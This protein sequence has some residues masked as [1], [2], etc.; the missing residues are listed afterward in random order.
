MPLKI[1][2]VC[3]YHS[4]MDVWFYAAALFAEIIGTMAG[5]GS[6]TILLPIALLFFDFKTA[7]VLV[8]FMH[9]F[10]NL[11]RSAFF[12]KGIHWRVLL[13]FG[14][15][16]V[17]ATS[18][19][20]LLVT[21][22]NQ[23]AL[24]GLLGVFLIIYGTVALTKFRLTLASSKR[25]M[26]IGGSVSGFFAGLIGTGGALRGAFL[27]A[28]TLPK[29]QYIGTAAA[30]AFLV[31]ITRI[32]VYLSS[33]LL[34]AS[35]YWTLPVLFMLAIIGSFIGKKLVTKIPKQV[36]TKV[37]LACIMLAGVKLVID[38]YAR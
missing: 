21:H 32:P 24:K 13:Y 2:G 1:G 22:I 34:A 15:A 31:D 23:A 16:S 29:A 38:F 8:A 4:I 27:T 12:R 33:D 37:V 20:A 5:F 35:H 25:N 3:E 14:S 18:I 30:I 36:F 11:G 17:I 28:F 19:G 6:S 10:G 7:L 26:F 9:L